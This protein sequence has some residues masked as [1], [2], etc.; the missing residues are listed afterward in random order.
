[1]TTSHPGAASPHQSHPVAVRK[2]TR[3]DLR[4]NALPRSLQYVHGGRDQVRKIRGARPHGLWSVCATKELR[5]VKW[6]EDM[7]WKDDGKVGRVNMERV[8]RYEVRWLVQPHRLP[9]RKQ[10]M[11]VQ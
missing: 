6:Y 1:M 2:H 5:E 9:L 3:Q 8:A 10:V 4:P 7:F 11:T